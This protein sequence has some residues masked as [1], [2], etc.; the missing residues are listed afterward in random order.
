MPLTEAEEE[1]IFNSLES[2]KINIAVMKNTLDS[3]HA[4][5]C[6]SLLMMEDRM[7]KFIEQHE[8]DLR[9]R[10][11]NWTNTLFRVFSGLVIAGVG[12]LAAIIMEFILNA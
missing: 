7:N 5:P 11:S 4:T 10:K 6:P 9:D 2:I 3:I 8:K 12:A 1:K